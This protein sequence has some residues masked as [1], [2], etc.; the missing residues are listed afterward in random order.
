MKYI[1]L[2]C[3][4]KWEE[5]GEK[6]KSSDRFSKG[7]NRYRSM[8]A[9]LNTIDLGLLNDYTSFRSTVLML[10][11]Y[12]M[13]KGTSLTIDLSDTIIHEQDVKEIAWMLEHT[14]LITK[15]R[16]SFFSK[17]LRTNTTLI[18]MN[19]SFSNIGS[20]CIEAIGEA[21]TISKKLTHM[22]LTSCYIENKGARIIGEALEINAKLTELLLANNRIE[23]EGAEAIGKALKVNA[24]LILLDI[25]FNLSLIHI[26]EPTRPY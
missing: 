23:S 8:K 2:D 21:L 16:C 15:Q 18:S 12:S 4:C 5:L 20:E 1:Q 14:N 26:S 6:F 17:I 10:S 9:C 25:G 7:N 11:D 24:A 22:N 19:L 3:G 13:R